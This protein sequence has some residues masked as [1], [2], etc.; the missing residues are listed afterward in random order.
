MEA[1]AIIVSRNG[2]VLSDMDAENAPAPLLYT[3]QAA[4]SEWLRALPPH[5]VKNLQDTAIAMENHGHGKSC[6]L[7][8]AGEDS[9]AQRH[10]SAAAGLTL[11]PTLVDVRCT[12][13][14]PQAC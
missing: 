10:H 6:W 8:V 4:G 7:G 5:L 9:G 3:D 12:V 1:L 13:F 2:S 11:E 14:T